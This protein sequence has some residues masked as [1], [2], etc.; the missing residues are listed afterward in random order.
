M[1]FNLATIPREIVPGSP[2]YPFS[3]SLVKLWASFAGRG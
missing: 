3:R 2:D 1:F